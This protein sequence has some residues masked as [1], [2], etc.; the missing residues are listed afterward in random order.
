MQAQEYS[1]ASPSVASD[2]EII[3]KCRIINDTKKPYP[4]H[5]RVSLHL[6]LF[7]ILPIWIPNYSLPCG[8][9]YAGGKNKPLL[10]KSYASWCLLL[11]HSYYLIYGDNELCISSASHNVHF[12]IHQFSCLRSYAGMDSRW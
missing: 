1:M 3:C 6:W 12:A 7:H 5:M 8:S 10:H 9:C 11:K 2:L 4:S